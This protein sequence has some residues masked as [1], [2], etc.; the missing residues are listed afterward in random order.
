MKFGMLTDLQMITTS[1]E[2]TFAKKQKFEHGGLLV[3]KIHVSF[4]GHI[5]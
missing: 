4:Y 2:N 1:T 3:A 5:S